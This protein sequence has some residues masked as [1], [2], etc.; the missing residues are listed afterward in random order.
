F[1]SRRKPA[2]KGGSGSSSGVEAVQDTEAVNRM[3]QMAESGCADGDCRDQ[4]KG[5]CDCEDG[6]CSIDEHRQKAQSKGTS[7]ASPSN[8]QKA[9]RWWPLALVALMLFGMFV[10][11]PLLNRQVN[12]PPAGA[13]SK[14][15]V[16]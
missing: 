11:L 12:A 1:A 13:H 16:E 4:E 10:G 3:R 5:D 15:T 9:A 14:V 2:G 8:A 6:I 7:G